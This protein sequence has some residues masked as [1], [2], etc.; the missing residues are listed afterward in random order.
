VQKVV[1]KS[2]PFAS[3]YALLP[4]NSNICFCMLVYSLHS[5]CSI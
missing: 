4:H 5:N 2:N 1:E 3:H